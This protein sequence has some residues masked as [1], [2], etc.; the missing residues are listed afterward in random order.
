MQNEQMFWERVALAGPDECWLWVAGKDT[1]GYGKVRWNGEAQLAHRV[2]YALTFGVIPDGANVLQE[3]RNPACCNPDHLRIGTMSPRRK[4]SE[5]PPKTT[6]RG[7]RRLPSELMRENEQL[8][9]RVRELEE[10]IR[11]LEQR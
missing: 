7:K 8:K 6:P 3:C 9:T 2:A 1:R 5:I 4:R 11:R 10:V